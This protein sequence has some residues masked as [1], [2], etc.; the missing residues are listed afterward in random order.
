MCVHV[1]VCGYIFVNGGTHGPE[2]FFSLELDLQM[3][4]NSVAW[5]LD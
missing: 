2:A 3:V 4:V 1:S 5:V